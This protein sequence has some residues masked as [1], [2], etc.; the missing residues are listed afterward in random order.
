MLIRF[1]LISLFVSSILGLS[2]CESSDAVTKE[3]RVSARTDLFTHV[4][5]PE[6]ISG[7]TFS[8]DPTK[9]TFLTSANGTIYR[10][11]ANALQDVN[12][13]A[14]SGNVEVEIKEV[15]TPVDFVMS[16]M[17]TRDWYGDI[18]QS[19]GMMYINATANGEQ[20]QLAKGSEIGVMM[21]NAYVDP[22]MSVY[23]GEQ[24]D[25]GMVWSETDPVLNETVETLDLSYREVRYYQTNDEATTPEQNAEISEWLWEEGRK[26]GD[27][28]TFGISEIEIISFSI[29]TEVMDGDGYTKFMQD[30]VV[31]K[32]K[33]GYV[34]DFN[35]SYIF[36]IKKLGWANIDKI[37]D[38]ER[39]REAR[40][41]IDVTNGDEFN[42]VY[43]T[44]VVPEYSIYIPGYQR[45][46]GM[47][48]FTQDDNDPSMLPLGAEAIVLCTGY[49]DT[50]PFVALKKIAL[51]KDN[52]MEV[53]LK[54]TDMVTL[55]KTL[56][57][58][59]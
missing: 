32:G 50:K 53:E 4:Y 27:K 58:N 52:V 56:D 31:N 47:Y 42:Y 46:N 33:N 36:S 30:I 41:A 8:I 15:L 2:S 55:R 43:T 22:D 48:C 23:E 25:S 35:T 17:T 40:F 44:L 24:T 34:E 37:Y 19:G 38:D 29:N 20:L 28:K 5:A 49:K 59:L 12:G 54:E 11:Y 1:I 14:V 51:E 21:P 6:N 16:N 26:P 7:E 3:E 45:L 57:E 39:S 13:V 9:D 10:L 18:L